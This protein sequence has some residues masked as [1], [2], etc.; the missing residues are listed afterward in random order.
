MLTV[1]LDCPLLIGNSVFSN[2]YLCFL[3]LFHKPY[4]QRD[5]SVDTN[6]VLV[7]YFVLFVSTYIANYAY[8]VKMY[9]YLA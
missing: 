5:F 8:N 4:I 2:V 6:F 1:F 9:L 3:Q 7:F